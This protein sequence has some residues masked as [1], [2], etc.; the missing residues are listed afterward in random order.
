MSFGFHDEVPAV[1]QAIVDCIA[2]RK[3]RITF[4]A[5]ASNSGGN[6][7]V[8]WPARHDAVFDIRATDLDGCFVSF[9]APPDFD[10]GDVFGTLGVNVEGAW[11]KAETGYKIDSGTSFATPIAAGIAALVLD[12]ARYKLQ[13]NGEDVPGHELELL[14]KKRGLRQVLRDDLLSKRMGRN[15]RYLSPIEFCGRDAKSRAESLCHLLVRR[16]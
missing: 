10:G 5:A 7:D 12:A 6:S 15:K 3:E 14:W 13:E 8:M 11:P 4:M 16:H 2:K 9:N 1:N